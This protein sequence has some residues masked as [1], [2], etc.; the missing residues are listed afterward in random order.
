MNGGQGPF[1]PCPFLLLLLLPSRGISPSFSFG[2]VYSHAAVRCLFLF[3]FPGLP[4][5]PGLH[6]G[7]GRKGII[8]SLYVYIY[9]YT[10]ARRSHRFKGIEGHGTVLGVTGPWRGRKRFIFVFLSFLPSRLAGLPTERNLFLAYLH[11][12]VRVCLLRIL[13][14][15]CEA[16]RFVGGS[17]N[18]VL[19]SKR[20]PFPSSPFAPVV[21]RNISYFP[22]I[23]HS[24][25]RVLYYTQTLLYFK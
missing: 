15:P 12:A 3:S 13:R 24:Y 11:V 14:R 16:L 5:F 1:S 9:V 7:P 8:C 25:T 2:T 23:L 17:Y 10:Y 18:G 4:V 6:R 21:T 22:T 20:V 19:N